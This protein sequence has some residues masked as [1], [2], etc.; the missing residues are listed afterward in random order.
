M[1]AKTIQKVNYVVQKSIPDVSE[2]TTKH[3]GSRPNDQSSVHPCG[4]KVDLPQWGLA[5]IL[6][7]FSTARLT[8]DR[9]IYVKKKLIGLGHRRRGRCGNTVAIR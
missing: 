8:S 6:P 5:K 9:N 7:S 2:A 4:K 1:E 3:Q